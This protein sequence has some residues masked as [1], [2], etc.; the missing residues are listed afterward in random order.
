MA[1][2]V[3]NSPA[4]VSMSIFVVR[5]FI[6]MREALSASHAFSEKLMELEQKLLG[7]L[8]THEKAIIHLLREIKKL[9]NIP[10]P[11]EPKKKPIGFVKNT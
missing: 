4:A 5:A 3:L 8:D 1:G 7:R 9:Q 10:L 6:K 2:T 11:P